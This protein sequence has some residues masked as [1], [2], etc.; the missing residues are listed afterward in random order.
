MYLLGSFTFD[1]YLLGSL[2][3]KTCFLLKAGFFV[4]FF[5]RAAGANFLQKPRGAGVAFCGIIFLVFG[6]GAFLW[7]S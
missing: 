5:L 7:L 6:K 4:A 1:M 2:S 3:Q